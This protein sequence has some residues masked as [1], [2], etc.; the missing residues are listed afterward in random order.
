MINCALCSVRPPRLHP[1]N[2]QLVAGRAPLPCA[3][4]LLPQLSTSSWSRAA[5]LDVGGKLMLFASCLCF[6][7]FVLSSFVLAPR[8][9]D[10]GSFQ[11]EMWPLIDAHR[12]RLLPLQTLTG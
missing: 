11:D 1:F 6:H 10:L 7:H 2:L 4:Q 5:T 3:P 12:A 9:L 8:T